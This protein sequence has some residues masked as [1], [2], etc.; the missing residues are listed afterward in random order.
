MGKLVSKFP[1]VPADP[2]S[3]LLCD[4]SFSP[5]GFGRLGAFNQR[6]AQSARVAQ[7]VEQRVIP[8]GCGFKSRRGPLGL[9]HQRAGTWQK[10]R[11]SSARHWP[12]TH[13]RDRGAGDAANSARHGGDCNLPAHHHFGCLGSSPSTTPRASSRCRRNTSS[14]TGN[15]A[16]VLWMLHDRGYDLNSIRRRESETERENRLLRE[17]VAALRRV[18]GRP[19]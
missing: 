3:H 4:G 18:I 19:V 10:L 5:A 9:H 11:G 1:P 17:E 2:V 12:M 16:P 8:T 15:D 7:S 13:G 14:R 6:G